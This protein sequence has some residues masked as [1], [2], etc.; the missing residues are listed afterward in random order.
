MSVFLDEGGF[1]CIYRK[2]VDYTF[3]SGSDGQTTF[4]SCGLRKY[5]SRET[6]GKICRFVKVKQNVIHNI[7]S[8]NDVEVISQTFLLSDGLIDSKMD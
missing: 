6:N 1:V 5:V 8:C 2:S 4:L 3:L 7:Y